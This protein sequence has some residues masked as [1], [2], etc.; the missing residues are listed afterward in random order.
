MT[1]I[2]LT[3]IPAA[4]MG[5]EVTVM[6]NDPLSLASVYELARLA[7]T[8]PYEILCRIGPRVKRV[9]V[10]PDDATVARDEAESMM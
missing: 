10:D 1:T 5:D 3:D 2:D 7:D 4:A 9:A 6:D 8:I